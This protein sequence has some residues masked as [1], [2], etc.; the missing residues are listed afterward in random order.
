MCTHDT[1]RDVS[2]RKA[3]RTQVDF[4]RRVR[5]ET[6]AEASSLGDNH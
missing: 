5:V 2:D 6:D 4:R 3:E 1:H